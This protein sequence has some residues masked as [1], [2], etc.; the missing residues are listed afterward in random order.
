M[1]CSGIPGGLAYGY[2]VVGFCYWTPNHGSAGTSIRA[3]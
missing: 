1:P 2:D 3:K